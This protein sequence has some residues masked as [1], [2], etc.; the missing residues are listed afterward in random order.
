[1]PYT[2]KQQ[3]AILRCLEAR[4]QQAMTA[5]ELAESLRASGSPV[6]LATVYRRLDRLAEAGR[7]HRVQTE[8]GAVYQYCP[9]GGAGRGCFLLRCEGCGRIVHL[10]CVR[11]EALYD[12][13]E[14]AHDFRVDPRR[15]VLAGRCRACSGE[16][17]AL[18]R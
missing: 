15:T 11:L 1:M 18:G 12:H 8:E 2:T 13:L 7:V 4:P 16:E 14:S 10:D 6:G 5:V 17:A 3:Q 9:E